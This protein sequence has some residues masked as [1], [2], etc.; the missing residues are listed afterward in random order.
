MRK[1][2]LILIVFILFLVLFLYSCSVSSQ[3]TKPINNYP[4]TTTTIPIS[5]ISLIDKI[6]NKL[7]ITTIKP[8]I[9]NKDIGSF[10]NC[11]FQIGKTIIINTNEKCRDNHCCM[12]ETNEKPNSH[13]YNYTNILTHELRHFYWNFY[14]TSQQKLDYCKSVNLN[15]AKECFERY[16]NDFE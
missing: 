8:T 10:W 12:Y 14:M 15:Y 6:E 13:L 7:N 9:I 1:N 11:G 3:E 16:S 2:P 5:E 4:T